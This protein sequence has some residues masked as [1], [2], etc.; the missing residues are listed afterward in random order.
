[1]LDRRS[2]TAASLA[3]LA[4]AGAARVGAAGAQ[5]EPLTYRNEVPGY[6]PLKRDPAGL[7]DLPE[8]FT[9]TV[10]SAAGEAMDDGFATPD[11]FDGMGIH[12]LDANRVALVRNH[13]LKPGDQE[14]GPSAGIARL[15]QRLKDGPAFGRGKDGR[16]LP[17]G[18]STLI[19]D[20]RSL[21][22]EAQWLSLAG[23]AVN[24]G[25]G[26]TPWGS[27]LTC[28]E[29][30]LKSPEVER[31]HGW[32]FEVP[33]AQRGLAQPR[34]LT[35]MGRFRHEAAAVDRK[36]GIFY[37]TE[38]QGDGLFTRFLPRD[39]RNLSAGGRLQALAVEGVPGMDTRNWSRPAFAPGAAP[40]VRWI[41]LEDVENMG[42]DL[43][44]RGR[45]AG[46]AIFARGEGIHAGN[47]E[48]YFTCTS[49]GAKKLGQIFR[50]IPSPAEGTPGE[51]AQ[52]GRLHLFLESGDES[53]FDYGDNLTVAPNGHLIVCEDRSD[54][55]PNHL[56]GV[57]P[58]GKVYTLALLRA[59]TE[60]AGACFSPDGKTM[61]VNVYRPGKTLAIRGPWDRVVTA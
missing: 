6:G 11:K 29:T 44:L 43:R 58:E 20:L 46:A 1:M 9:Y 61:F 49:G 59:D 50:Y 31:P 37:L 35:A 26:E 42:D 38:D 23:T 10:V 4:F 16:V 12:A 41:D 13:E 60:L 51:S 39:P 7:F 27:W 54:K 55:E 40:A 32:I 34:P 47:G 48:F 8:G 19:V 22:R 30:V 52:P 2:F 15:E 24:C 5:A 36:T 3:S 17:G 25:G 53:V 57:T 56:R 33:A 18:T 28:E 14:L 21:K 45:Q